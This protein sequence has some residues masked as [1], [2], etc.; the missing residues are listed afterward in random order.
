MNGIPLRTD[1]L[2][3]QKQ[4]Y[5]GYR[6]SAGPALS[7]AVSL[8]VDEFASFGAMAGRDLM[9][10]PETT[11][12]SPRPA[13]MQRLLRRHAA[14]GYLAETVPEMLSHAEVVHA[15]RQDLIEAMV[16][17]VVD[18]DTGE[19][20]VARHQH[21]LVIRRFHRFLESNPDQPVYVPEIC[22]A[23]NVSSRTLLSCCQEHL[24]LSP[25]QFLKKRRF[26]L[27]NRALLD[28]D[29]ASTTVT[30]VAMRF[31]FYHLGRFAGEYHAI[32]SEAPSVTL[33]R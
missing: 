2:I 16:D 21:D 27:V 25:K 18:A 4:G 14:V 26:Y 17:C 5:E 29:P 30:D 28:A 7:G 24:A 32:Y 22:R 31:G 10:P 8:P 20:S 19:D 13:A 3:W 1:N 11:S 9:P 12:I 33:H 6:Y 15:I 23:I